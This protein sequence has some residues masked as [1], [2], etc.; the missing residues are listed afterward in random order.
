MSILD[1]NIDHLSSH[2]QYILF[3]L[4]EKAKKMLSEV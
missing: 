4:S 1:D 2:F 3:Q